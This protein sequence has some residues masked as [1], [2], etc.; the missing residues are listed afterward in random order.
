MKLADKLEKKNKETLKH[1]MT[2]LYC[3]FSN[4]D[5]YLEDINNPEED[6]LYQGKANKKWNEAEQYLRDYINN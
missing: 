2:V 4:A 5:D 3:L 1:L 6:E